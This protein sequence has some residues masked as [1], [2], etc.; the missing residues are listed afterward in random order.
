MLN[1]QAAVDIKLEETGE[2]K[3]D[4][5][6]SSIIILVNSSKSLIYW[7]LQTYTILKIST[8]RW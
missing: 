5:Y 3:E 8:D 2:F 4:F 6:I 1:F 7:K